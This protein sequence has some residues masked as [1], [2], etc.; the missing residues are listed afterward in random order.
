MAS[1]SGFDPLCAALKSMIAPSE[2][3]DLMTTGAPYKMPLA[4]RILLKLSG[5]SKKRWLP[6]PGMFATEENQLLAEKAIA[7]ALRHSN[8]TIFLAA[9]ENQYARAFRDAP[10][11]V[12]KRIVLCLHQPPSYLKLHW[13]DSH[14]LDGLKAIVCL[15]REQ[16]LYLEK[17]TKTPV[18]SILHGVATDFFVPNPGVSPIRN[19]IL[20]VGQWLRDFALLHD[21]I[22]ELHGKR[23]DFR[24]DCVV[25]ASTRHLDPILRLSRYD[26]VFWHS[27]LSAERLRE[28]YWNASV[29]FQPLIDATANNAV[30]EAMS[31]G[32]PVVATGVGGLDQ[33]IQQNTGCL[34]KPG[35]GSDHAKGLIR[36]LEDR[37]T[38]VLDGKRAREFALEQLTWPKIASQLSDL[39]SGKG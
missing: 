33:Y 18:R 32:L 20:F 2:S 16:K 15:S 1:V 30:V 26:N 24:L 39:F 14:A 37:D 6:H 31:C 34:C 36:Y 3:F 5:S 10:E 9:G 4:R 8:A 12:R 7:L 17:M 11:S 38:A 28:L 27:D 29:L 13:I 35:D 25:S 19:R 21:T 23:T 22:R